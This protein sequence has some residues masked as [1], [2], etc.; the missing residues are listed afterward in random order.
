MGRV[1]PRD[2]GLSLILIPAYGILGG[3]FASWAA[4]AFV[5]LVYCF[6]SGVVQVIDWRRFWG[7]RPEILMGRRLLLG[8]LSR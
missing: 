5:A 2:R 4:W 7:F 1:P 3:I 6:A 8:V